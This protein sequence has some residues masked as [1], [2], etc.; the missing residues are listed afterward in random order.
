VEI[1]KV[2]QGNALDM[3]G[4]IPEGYTPVLVTDPPFNI[5]YHYEGYSDNM[6][7]NEYYSML[8]E[9]VKAVGGKAVI[10]HYPEALHKLSIKLGVAPKRVVSWVYNSNTRRQHRDIAY[11]GFSPK[12]SQVVQPYKNP[13]DKRIM[14]RI[15]R[16]IEGGA[17]YDWFNVNQVKNVSSIKKKHP[18]QMPLQVMLNVVGVIPDKEN[19]LIVDPFCGTGTTLVAAHK[20]G[21]AYIGFDINENYIHIAEDRLKTEAVAKSYKQLKLF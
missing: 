14:E 20:L 5:G 4:R 16:G 17:L 1:N 12:M 13:T 6:D 8:G 18:C 21:Y 15:S 19:V 2:Y 3:I 10:V 9:L 11:Y 7:E